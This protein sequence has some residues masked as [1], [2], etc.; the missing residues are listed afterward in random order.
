[1]VDER[2]MPDEADGLGRSWKPCGRMACSRMVAGMR[3]MK[4]GEGLVG[5]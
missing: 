1:M 4:E 3:G 2:V 5:R